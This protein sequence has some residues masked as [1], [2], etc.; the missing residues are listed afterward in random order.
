LHSALGDRACSGV[1]RIVALENANAGGIMAELQSTEAHPPRAPAPALH[2]T[3]AHFVL[4]AQF[5]DLPGEVVEKAKAQ[6]AYLLGL[7]F[8]GNYNYETDIVRHVFGPLDQGRQGVTVIGQQVRLALADAA[9][10]NAVM[11]R[12]WFLDDVLFPSTVHA[13]TIT[14]PAALVAGEFARASGRDLLLAMALGYEVMGKL[15]REVNLWEG[16]PP[17]RGT[18]VFGGYGPVIAA[19]RLLGLNAAQLTNALGYAANLCMGVPEDGQMDHFYGF[20]SRNGVL[21]ALLARAGGV[22]YSRYTL[23]GELGLYR[24]FFGKV[25]PQLPQLVA[26]LGTTWEIVNSEYKRH[27][28][29]GSNTPGIELLL[30]LLRTHRLTVDQVARVR[31]AVPES[32]RARRE[33]FNAGPFAS[34]M[35]AYS[36]MPYALARALLQGRVEAD[37]YTESQI[38]NPVAL[39]AIRRFEFVFENRPTRYVRIELTTRGGAVHVAEIDGLILPFP[40]AEWGPWLRKDGERLLGSQAIRVLE[41]QITDLEQLPDVNALIANLRPSLLRRRSRDT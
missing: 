20:F 2:E 7:A 9:F 41:Q 32:R 1:F 10:A 31:V 21:S 13:G 19:G 18:M 22:P 33:N 12:A 29:T 27:H 23:E 40:R 39:E 4:R 30:E 15:G 36:S 17:R 8:S 35:A 14:L 26:K 24:S 16:A 34:P 11:M 3:I 37:Q 28:T 6:V 38:R 25:P 5:A